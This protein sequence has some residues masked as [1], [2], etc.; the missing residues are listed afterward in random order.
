MSPQSPKESWLS[1][2]ICHLPSAVCGLFLSSFF[3][4]L[5]SSAVYAE[6]FFINTTYYND[7]LTKC[8]DKCSASDVCPKGQQPI[9]LQ[10]CD[11]PGM[12]CCQDISATPKGDN[13]IGTC[14]PKQ[15]CVGGNDPGGIGGGAS[16]CFM[17]GYVCCGA[18]KTTVPGT[19]QAQPADQ[20]AAK[21]AVSSNEGLM[22]DTPAG[23]KFPCP[24]NKGSAEN[25]SKLIGQIIRWFLGLIGALFF[26]MF[27]WGGVLYMTAGSSKRAEEGQKTLVNAAIGMTIVICSYLLVTWVLDI[28]GASIY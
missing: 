13:C 1:S 26:A 9:P 6:G 12:V 20:G 19:E 10:G 24:F 7:G 15:N 28:I 14:V 5:S 23:V 21:P 4:L 16:T 2:N 27:V 8:V 18:P 25:I 17:E 22:C 3:F 11:Q